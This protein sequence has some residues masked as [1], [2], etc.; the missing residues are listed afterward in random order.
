MASGRPF[1]TLLQRQLHSRANNI[2]PWFISS[3]ILEHPHEV[4]STKQDQSQYEAKS[5]PEGVPDHVKNLHSALQSSPFLE[6]SQ[7]LVCKPLPL[8][9]GPGLPRRR[10]SGTRRKRRQT[11]AGYGIEHSQSLWDW[12]VYA[13]VKEGT[14]NRGAIEAVMRTVRSTLQNF[15]PTLPIPRNRRQPTEEGWVMLDVGD[16]A[17]HILSKAARERYFGSEQWLDNGLQY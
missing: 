16:V 9:D 17:I 13:Q 14:E 3:K 5:L 1:V 11:F 4:S 2:N 10:T 12:A 15:D 8:G 6:L 7:L